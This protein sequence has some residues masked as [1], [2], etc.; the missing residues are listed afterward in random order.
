[1][2]AFSIR[3]K[4]L[5]R[6]RSGLFRYCYIPEVQEGC[7]LFKTEVT[8][9]WRDEI[10]SKVKET[11]AGVTSHPGLP[12]IVFPHAQLSFSD[13]L[14]LFFGY[15]MHLEGSQFPDHGLN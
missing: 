14:F 3:L 6:K 13:F 9:D 1:M 5:R 8:W 11:K 7:I 15:A 2:S 4:T 12:E 10:C